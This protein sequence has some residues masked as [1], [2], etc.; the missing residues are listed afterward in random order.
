M[1][2][3]HV[4]GPGRAAPRAQQGQS[5]AARQHTIRN[6]R[7]A[8]R[9]R[10]THHDSLTVLQQ[11]MTGSQTSSESVEPSSSAESSRTRSSEPLTL[12]STP[13]S[14]Q[15]W[16]MGPLNDEIPVRIRRDACQALTYAPGDWFNPSEATSELHLVSESHLVE[17]DE[18]ADFRATNQNPQLFEYLQPWPDGTPSQFPSK[19]S[20]GATFP[21]D[22]V[23]QPLFSL[24]TVLP[25]RSRLPSDFEAHLDRRIGRLWDSY[26]EFTAAMPGISDIFGRVFCGL[27]RQSRIMAEEGVRTV[28]F[29][30]SIS[31]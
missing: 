12:F 2:L 14:Q 3:N 13:S 23:F 10:P 17:Y 28:E 29:S 20:G 25:S 6:A 27:F 9:L 19:F 18:L 30:F 31:Y 5:E 1:K 4:C 26:E 15:C 7:A 11:P 21:M 22:M 24:T 16:P 8:K